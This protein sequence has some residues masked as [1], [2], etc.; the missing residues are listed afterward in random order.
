MKNFFFLLIFSALL[1]GCGGDDGDSVSSS[2]SGITISGRIAS[3]KSNV[4]ALSPAGLSDYTFYCVAFNADADSCS[5]QLDDDGNFECTGIPADT[6]F[7]CFVKDSTS[8]VAT[9]EFTDTATGFENETSASTALSGSVSL[10]S[11]TLNTTTGKATV[12]KSVL[13]GKVSTG[14]S[15]LTPLDFQ[16]TSWTLSCVNGSD[17]LMN[18]LCSEFVTESPTVYFRVL[19]ATK[20]SDGGI[21]YGLGVWKNQAAFTGCG[22]I[23][24]V[25]AMKS[26]IESED[27]ITFDTISHAAAFN[28]AHA[29]GQD[30]ETWDGSAPADDE[31]SD[32][33]NYYSLQ[34]LVNNGGSYT[35]REEDEDTDGGCTYTHTLAVTFNPVSETLMYGAFDIIEK[36]SGT[37]CN[38]EEISAKFTVKFTKSE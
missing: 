11:V 24:M 37:G 29:E 4:A 14:S 30:C 13:D 17:T 16:G 36:E 34:K 3:S 19:K 5:D 8:I 23:D 27:N 12:A 31:P 33:D 20:N 22:S 10:G 38:D 7:G 32:I 25:T 9:L 28:D 21:I 2:S 6:A 18:L 1:V 26:A 35:L 15:S